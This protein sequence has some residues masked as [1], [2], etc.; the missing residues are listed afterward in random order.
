MGVI[1]REMKRVAEEYLGEPVTQAVITVP[2][3]FNDTQRQSTKGCRKDRGPR[4]AADHQRA[5]R[6]RFRPTESARERNE[7][8]AV[9]DLGGG[10]FDIS[11]LEFGSGVVEVLATAGN[12]FLGGEDFDRRHRRSRMCSRSFRNPMGSICAAT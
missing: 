7:K 2:A 10:T 4:S 12:T 5:D 11:I 6:G 9:Y 8:I 3:Y 1:V